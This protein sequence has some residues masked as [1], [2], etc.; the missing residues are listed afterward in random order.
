MGVVN[1]T[2]TFSGT[3]TITSS[4]LNNIIDDT[5]FTSNA[6]QGTTLEVA[7]GQLKIRSQGITS[8]ELSSDLASTLL[9]SGAVM[10]F[11]RD[12]APTGWLI[13]DGSLIS[14]GGINALLFA[15]IQYTYGGSGG[16]F[17][18][19]DLR[20]IFVRGSGSQIISGGTFAGTFA[21]KQA[22]MFQDHGHAGYTNSA[23]SHAHS[24]WTD[25]Q[26]SHSH[27]ASAND[28]GGNTHRGWNASYDCSYG[29]GG[30]KFPT[31]TGGAHSHN[32]GTHGAGDHTHTIQ[33]YG[34][35]S[36]TTG[37]ETRPANIAL[38]YCIKL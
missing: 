1:T 32:V 13:A 21:Q 12:S 5:T 15:A 26:G 37:G 36:G 9:P 2:Y 25:V 14:T 17:N 10:P 18:L 38:L 22:H 11:A 4:K 16:S 30:W 8:N 27:G 6:I 19:P 7:S 29:G 31:E 20:G 28:D 34:A 33:T 23:G 35:N 3:D 24:G